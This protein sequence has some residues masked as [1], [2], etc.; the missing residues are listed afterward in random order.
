MNQLLSKSP[1][2]NTAPVS[3]VVS[4]SAI[5]TLAAQ[6]FGLNLLWQFAWTRRT[7]FCNPFKVFVQWIMCLLNLYL[8]SSSV[9]TRVLEIVFKDFV[10][11]FFSCI[12]WI[13]FFN[14]RLICGTWKHNFVVSNNFRFMAVKTPCR[15][16]IALIL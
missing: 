14:V 4:E 3:V 6:A 5:I 1:A 8:M 15:P 16:I 9:Y 13:F 12:L 10:E 11:H 2:P 7:P